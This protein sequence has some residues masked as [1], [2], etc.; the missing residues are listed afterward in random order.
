M[1]VGVNTQRDFIFF[2][3]FLNF[4]FFFSSFILT[5]YL[6]W[7]C[8]FIKLDW[9]CLHNKHT[10]CASKEKRLHFDIPATE[11]VHP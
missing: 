11:T 5:R 8:L 1:C 2:I 10:S 7:M 9:A 3:P 4:L 6:D